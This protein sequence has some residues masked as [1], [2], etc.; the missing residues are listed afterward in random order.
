MKER[1]RGKNRM[2]NSLFFT[3]RSGFKMSSNP[4]STPGVGRGGAA[5]AAAAT[6]GGCAASAAAAAAATAFPASCSSA[7]G[8][9]AAAAAAGGG[10][11]SFFAAAAAAAAAVAAAL[12]SD[13]ARKR[14]AVHFRFFRLERERMREI[15]L[16]SKENK[17]KR[18]EKKI[19][20]TAEPPQ[21]RSPYLP[22]L[23]RRRPATSRG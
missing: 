20:L 3:S 5:A 22:L 11:S 12:A 17:T 18:T 4:G 15:F 7:R 9:A 16:F 19:V 2:K 14:S 21:P 6:R 13:S 1:E 10:A 23:R 8:T